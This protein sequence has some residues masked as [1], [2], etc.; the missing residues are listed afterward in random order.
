[1]TVEGGSAHFG[2]QVKSIEEVHAAIERFKTA[3]LEIVTEEATTCCYAVQDKVW[4]V[5]PDGINEKCSWL[6]KQMP[7]TSS[8]LNRAVAV[9]KWSR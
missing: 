2:V 7:K 1:M 5:D 3:N 6:L 8:T 4:V 9:Q